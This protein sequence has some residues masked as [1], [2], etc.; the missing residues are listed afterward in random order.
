MFW[1]N[2]S[3]QIPP[4]IAAD[5]LFRTGKDSSEEPGPQGG[6]IKNFP[7]IHPVKEQFI[8]CFIDNGVRYQ[9]EVKAF[10]MDDIMIYHV[11]YSIAPNVYPVRS[12]QIY[13]GSAG[14]KGIYWRQRITDK[15]EELLPPEFVEAAGRAIEE[16]GE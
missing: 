6:G 4:G 9:A 8:I 7:Y 2:I 5:I 12:V 3:S 14:G 13:P 11:Y 15:E 10:D 1:N 16:V